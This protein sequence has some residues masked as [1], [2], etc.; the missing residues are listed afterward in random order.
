MGLHT[1]TTNFQK[2]SA[3]IAK[4][5]AMPESSTGHDVQDLQA[6]ALEGQQSLYEVS[7][8]VYQLRHE[9]QQLTAKLNYVTQGEG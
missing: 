7:D 8:E 1:T 5:L 6:L 2:V 3:V 9:V 4:A